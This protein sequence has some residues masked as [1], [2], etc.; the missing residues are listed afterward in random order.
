MATYMEPNY[1]KGEYK[2]NRQTLINLEAS[3]ED[4]YP[5]LGAS[6]K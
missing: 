1:K 5:Q 6:F 3:K 4:I 2:E